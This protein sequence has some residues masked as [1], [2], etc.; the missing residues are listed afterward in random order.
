MTPGMTMLLM[1]ALAQAGVPVQPAPET[2]AQVEG[3]AGALYDRM[4]TDHKRC[5][6]FED[7]LAFARASTPPGQSAAALDNPVSR[8][9]FAESDGNSDGCV[10]RTEAIAS[11]GRTF[12]AADRNGDGA[13]DVEEQVAFARGEAERFQ[14]RFGPP[15]VRPDAS[16]SDR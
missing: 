7:L 14:R 8:A 1:L 4:N 6:A 9:M 11:A 13:V 10:A 15:P 2:R 12:A 16:G 3:R 5:L